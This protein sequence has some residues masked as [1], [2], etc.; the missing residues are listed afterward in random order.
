MYTYINRRAGTPEK[1][2][3]QK[4]TS[5]NMVVIIYCY[6]GCED[7]MMYDQHFQQNMDQPGIMVAN[8]AHGQL[9]RENVFFP[10]PIRACELASRDGFRSSRHASACSFS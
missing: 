4:S 2:R 1:Q 6:I 9:D 8:L 5:S 7:C 3:R 10:V